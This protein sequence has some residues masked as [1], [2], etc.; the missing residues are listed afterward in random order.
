MIKYGVSL[1]LGTP[2]LVGGIN[3][4]LH[5]PLSDDLDFKLMDISYGEVSYI[6]MV[7]TITTT[8][9]GVVLIVIGLVIARQK[10]RKTSK[11]LITS[12][13]EE[14][15]EFPDDILT[16][17][18]K[19]DARE[20]IKLG[21]VETEDYINQSIKMFNAE[22]AVNIYNRFILNHN[23]T[24]ILLGGRAR[25]PFLVAYGS[26]FRNS[27]AKIVYFDQLHQNQK[28]EL[29]NDVNEDISIK[30]EDIESIVANENGDIGLAI[31]FTSQ[32]LDSQLPPSIKDH[33]LMISSSIEP[34][35]N[36]I[37]N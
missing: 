36:L 20:T 15:V 34:T 23:C 4:L 22:E 5:I 35:R 13:L 17:M 30:Y 6:S 12:M 3:L 1:L 37:K 27:S 26:R 18:E 24:K 25:V 19:K 8:I 11:I 21:L 9:I 2:L 32:I 28:W 10:A 31:S 29:L 16:D 33:T 7:I 14:S